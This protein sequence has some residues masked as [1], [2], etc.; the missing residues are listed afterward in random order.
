M[1]KYLYFICTNPSPISTSSKLYSLTGKA[2]IIYLIT[3][4]AKKSC[5][6]LHIVHCVCNC[7]LAPDVND[8]TLIWTIPNDAKNLNNDWNPGTWVLIWECSARAIQWIPTWWGLDGFQKSLHPCA[9]DE[10]SLRTGRVKLY[11]VFGS[12]FSLQMWRR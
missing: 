10:S 12:P 2:S 6:G 8:L 1:S 3:Y 4:H 7:V 5:F 11:K 9:V